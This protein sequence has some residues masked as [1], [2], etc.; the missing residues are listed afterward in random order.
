MKLH[1]IEGICSV[2]IVGLG[3]IVKGQNKKGILLLLAFYFTL[4]AILYAS[5]LF[6]GYLPLYALGFV[7]ISGI[8]LWIYS[9]ADALL[10]K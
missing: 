2:L 10:R 6:S 1:F 4:P 8:I 5:L 9:V 7:L 3:Q